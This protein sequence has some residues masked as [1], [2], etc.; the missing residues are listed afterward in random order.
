MSTLSLDIA[1]PEEQIYVE[2][3][4]G[5]HNLQVKLGKLS[6]KEFKIKEIRRYQYLKSLGWKQIEINSPNDCLPN[7]EELLSCVLEGINL[8]KTTN[9]NHHTINLYKNNTSTAIC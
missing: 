4:G 1:F 6:E 8:L 9:I 3:N 2:Y 5:G 7:D